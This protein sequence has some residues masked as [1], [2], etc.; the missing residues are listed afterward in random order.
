[1]VKWAQFWLGPSVQNTLKFS[2]NL[3]REIFHEN[4]I[5]QYSESVMG[6]VYND[7]K[8]EEMYI[9]RIF[10]S[11]FRLTFRHMSRYLSYVTGIIKAKVML[12]IISLDVSS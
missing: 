2:S 1:M 8:L 3:H 5:C 7:R 4:P 12:R 10:L 6:T 9:H 11:K